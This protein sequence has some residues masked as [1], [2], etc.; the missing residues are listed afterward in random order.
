MN[1]EQGFQ[2]GDLNR[3]LR[4]RATLA[5]GV[6]AAVVLAALLVSSFVPNRYDASAVLLIEPQ[7]ISERLVES[8]L[9]E[10]DLNSRL[11][12]I[13]MQILSRGRLSQVIDELDVYPEESRTLTREEVIE[14]MRGDISVVPLLSEL[15]SQA[16]VRSRDLQ[17][18]TFQLTFRHTDPEMAAAVANKLARSYVDE[19]IRERTR[20]SSD[21]SEFIEAEL[22]RLATRIAEVEGEIAR[23][24]SANTGSLPEDLASN[25][26]LHE[27][28]IQ[29][30]RDVQRDLSLAESDEAF[31]RQQVATGVSDY[32]KYQRASGNTPE[33]RLEMLRL[34]LKD[35]ES[36]RFTDKHPDVISTKAQIAELEAEIEAASEGGELSNAQQTAS[37]EQNRAALRAASAR[38]ELARLRE[39]VAAIEERLAK[40]PRVQEQ[41]ASLE[42][43]YE[44]LSDSYHEF[45]SKRL[46]AGVAAD[47][48]RRQKGERFRVLE[49]AVAPLDA[50]SPNRPLILLLA[51]I[52][53]AGAGTGMALLAEASDHSFHSSRTL[54]ERVGI[55]VLAT[56]PAVL[57]ASDHMAIRRRRLRRVAA[58]AALA[59]LV[60]VV[61]LAG[62]WYVNGPPGV[63]SGLLG[64]DEQGSPAGGGR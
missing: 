5:A 20:A 36:R 49:E 61:S 28:L 9:E 27:R 30:M 11:H 56:V 23:V 7:T 33:S 58:A 50:A 41:L 42:R 44:H 32:Y 1:A 40:T 43:E 47:M 15:E 19:H 18:N 22:S 60:L 59:G 52:L 45:S 48:E 46:E 4:R 17:I 14:M 35:Y 38:A 21:T 55:P 25:Q 24:K 54:Q 13:Q 37:A 62:N 3:V 8:N 64:G 6:T 34:Q 10:T 31:F 53:G 26:R 63:V 16:G 29:Q 2:L 39:Q 51:L 57:L 12:L